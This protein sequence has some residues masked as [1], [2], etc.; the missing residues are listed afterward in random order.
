MFLSEEN[1]AG[2]LRY[3][4]LPGEPVDRFSLA[5][6]SQNPPEGVLRLGRETAEDRDHLLVA[7]AG[8]VPLGD[9]SFIVMKN[10]TF[11]QILERV[12]AVREGLRSH[13]IPPDQLVLRPEW[14][15]LSEEDG[16]VGLVVLPTPLAR[17]LSLS[18]ED[19][20]CLLRQRFPGEEERAA[21]LEARSEKESAKTSASTSPAAKPLRLRLREF[22]E[23]LD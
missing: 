19:Y 5:V 15:F 23:N 1:G 8:Y 11:E 2:L 14:T 17:D 7:V 13:M 4:L 3:A 22:W 6:L 20:A 12:T 18:P 10:L 21:L 9:A 16:A